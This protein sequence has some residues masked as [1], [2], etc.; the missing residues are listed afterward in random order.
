MKFV[1]RSRELGRVRGALDSRPSKVVLVHGL[2]GGGKT[3]LLRRILPD[4]TFVYYPC[5]ALPDPAQRAG[6]ATRIGA[7][8]RTLGLAREEPAADASWDA[9][10]A[11]LKAIAKG[12]GATLVLVLDDAH[13]LEE[14]RSRYRRPLAAM[15]LESDASS[16]RD[17][18]EAPLHV[19][20][21]GPR[22]G[23]PSPEDMVGLGVPTSSV[24]SVDVAPLPFRAAASLLPG[25]R[26]EDLL[27]AYAVFGGIPRVLSGLDT[28]LTIGTNIRRFLLPPAGPI[29]DA[30]LW[31]E[32][33]VQTPARYNAIL[34]RLALGEADWGRV[35]RGVSDLTR[36][37]QVAPYL[38]RLSELGLVT[39]RR[40]LDA[41]PGSRSTR[42]SITDPFLAFWYR[43]AFPQADEDPPR[44]DAVLI[45]LDEETVSDRYGRFVRPNLDAHFQTVFPSICR[46]HMEFDALTTLGATARTNGS[47]WGRGYEVPVAGLLTSGAAYYGVC[48]WHTPS[49]TASPLDELEANLTDTRYGFGRERRLRLVFTP[50]EAPAWLLRA[51]ARREDALVVDPEALLG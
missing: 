16:L 47:L 34:A 17:D 15:L 35:H 43:F 23:I 45:G 7:L 6:L 25:A 33:D 51:V 39:A 48:A 46:Q 21:V 13:R 2:R 11:S 12:S 14:A 44:P 37:G 30:T 41:E 42:Y 49:P 27:R 32:R 19:V 10:L 36:S 1:G 50:R 31:L 3:A 18:G 5:P 4:Y 24:E 28:S 20:L 9:L 26:P 8:Q 38:E 40:P 29:G 22:S